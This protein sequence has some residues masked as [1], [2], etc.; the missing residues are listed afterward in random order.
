MNRRKIV[1]SIIIIFIIMTMLF[2]F[3]NSLTSGEAS[4]E[5]SGFISEKIQKIL[6]PQKKI[7]PYDFHVFIRKTAHFAEFSLLGAELMILTLLMEP[8][9][10]FKLIF[11]PLF[12]SLLT[13]TADE[14]LQSFMTRTSSVTDVLIDFSGSVFG[15]AMIIFAFETFKF[16]RKR[17]PHGV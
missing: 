1:F 6:D 8:F 17:K 5:T 13:G 7:D 9:Y 15:I 11:M 3:Q 14:Y 12:I 4:A 2:I 16:I 10:Y